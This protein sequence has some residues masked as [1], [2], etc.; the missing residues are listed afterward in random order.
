MKYLR[1]YYVT[2]C[3]PYRG[4]Y[5]EIRSTNKDKAFDSVV[6]VYGILNVSSVYTEKAWE[7]KY[8]DIFTSLGYVE[9]EI[10][11][12]RKRFGFKV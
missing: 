2:L 5:V 11:K 6:K 9:S 8:T 1:H 10:E 7:R 4:K 3:G 12:Q